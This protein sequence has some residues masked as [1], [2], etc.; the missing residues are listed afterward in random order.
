MEI[1]NSVPSL[2]PILYVF[3]NILAHIYVACEWQKRS[4]THPLAA[5]KLKN[6]H[7]S[8][9]IKFLANSL[10]NIEPFIASGAAFVTWIAT[11]RADE[12][13]FSCSLY[14]PCAD[15]LLSQRRR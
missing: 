15:F 12:K 2:I 4:L 13:K 11:E 6:V 3:I 8:V 7:T 1:R 10:H 14:S 5:N 9:G